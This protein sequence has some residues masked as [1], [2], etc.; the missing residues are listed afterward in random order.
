[1]LDSLAGPM[2]SYRVVDYSFPCGSD[3]F[4]TRQVSRG[5]R[6]VGSGGDGASVC[7]CDVE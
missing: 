3:T 2:L 5:G 6:V 1:M 4:G 7:S